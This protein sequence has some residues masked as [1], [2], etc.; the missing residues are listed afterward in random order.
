[1]QAAEAVL[2]HDGYSYEIRR[3]DPNRAQ[4]DLWVSTAPA[5][6]FRESVERRKREPLSEA[7]LRIKTFRSE[8]VVRDPLRK[9]GN[10]ETLSMVMLDYDFHG[11]AD[12]FDLDAVFYAEAIEKTGWTI[13]FPVDLVGRRVMAVFVD[14]YGN[15]AREL[16]P[17]ER[18]SLGGKKRSLAVKRRRPRGKR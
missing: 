13:R 12:V 14:M 7:V 1:L 3:V 16:I 8:A 6:L 18:F 15:E 9:K 17:A 2:T 11:A 5:A 4:R 10:R